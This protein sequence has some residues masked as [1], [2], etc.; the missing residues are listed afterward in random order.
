[1]LARKNYSYR[2]RR[3]LNRSSAQR[4]SAFLRAYAQLPICKTRPS[5][6][7]SRI[8]SRELHEVSRSKGRDYIQIIHNFL[9]LLYHYQHFLY[10]RIKFPDFPLL[11]RIFTPTLT[12]FSRKLHIKFEFNKVKFV[13]F[14]AQN[15][16]T[17]LITQPYSYT[18]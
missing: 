5:F 15:S 14:F 7:D 1:M 8:V 18:R 12:S 13:L 17:V 2:T 16:F 11:L 6:P 9:Q 3:E 10:R 4:P